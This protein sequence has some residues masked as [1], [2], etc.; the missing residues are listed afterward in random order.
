MDTIKLVAKNLNCLATKLKSM[1]KADLTVISTS[2]DME[3]VYN[4]N[5]R[6]VTDAS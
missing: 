4:I 6:V 5:I 1:Y 3:P 2:A